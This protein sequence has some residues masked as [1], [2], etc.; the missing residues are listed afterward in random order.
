MSEIISNRSELL[1]L[2]DIENANPNGDPLNENRPRFDTESSTIL[3]S[4]VRLK[5]TIRDYWYEYKGF[6]GLSDNQ[7]IFVRET[8]YQDGDKEYIKDG[9]RRAKDFQEQATIILNKCIDIRVFGGVIPLSNDSITY[10]GPVQFQMGK[11]LNKTE[12][13]EEQGT[14]AFASGDKKGQ[15]TFRTEYKIPYAVL[16][17]NGV[18]NEKSA[19]YSNMNEDDKT[20]LIEGIW[21]GTKNLISRSKFGQAP[22]LLLTIDYTEP[23]YIG[24]LRQRLKLDCGEKNEMQIRSTNDFK[25]DVTELVEVLK[26]NKEKIAAISLRTDSRLTMVNKGQVITNISKD[27]L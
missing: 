1:F 2:Y 20:L 14:G 19:Q 17:F 18:I 12:I 15:A 21:E 23:F 22:L 25:L 11:S 13:V 24:N 26:A 3:V 4:D 7:D 16:G 5:R 27:E 8:T 10:I 9:K 6:N